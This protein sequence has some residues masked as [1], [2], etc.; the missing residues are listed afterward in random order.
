MTIYISNEI[1]YLCPVATATTCRIT[2]WA[3]PNNHL[4]GSAYKNILVAMDRI[5]LWRIDP[6]KHSQSEVHNLMVLIEIANETNDNSMP[7]R[8]VLAIFYEE[9]SKDPR[10]AL[11]ITAPNCQEQNYQ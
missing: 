2:L 4:F 7:E 8:N 11:R 1:Q 3:F 9:I 6:T 5:R 10:E